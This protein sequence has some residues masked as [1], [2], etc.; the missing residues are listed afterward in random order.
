MQGPAS[1]STPRKN[2]IIVAP[3][4]YDQYLKR[5]FNSYKFQE[6]LEECIKIY[7]EGFSPETG[8]GYRMKDIAMRY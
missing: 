6:A 7:P 5:I 4:D 8:L 1:K 3:F 2:R